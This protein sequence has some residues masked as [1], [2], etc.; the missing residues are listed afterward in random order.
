MQR[1]AWIG[2]C[3]ERIGGGDWANDRL[4]PD[5][6]RA[7]FDGNEALIRT[8][9]QFVHG[10]TFLDP[11]CGYLTLAEKLCTIRNATQRVGIWPDESESLP[12]A[13]VLEQL[14]GLWGPGMAWRP[15]GAST[16]TRLIP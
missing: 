13:T 10:S 7:V 11:L 9:M 3:R 1:P 8:L 6:M 12:V 15:D 5:V 16:T 14:R 4:I 2:S